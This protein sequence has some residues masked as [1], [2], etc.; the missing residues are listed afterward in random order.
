MTFWT[1][2]SAMAIIALFFVIGNMVSVKT[3]GYINSVL[4]AVIVF[5]ALMY[6]GVVPADI[7]TT[8]GLAGMVGTFVIP[9]CIVDVASKLKLKELKSEWKT[10]LIIVIASL[11]IVAICATVG[12]LA[13]GKARAIGAIGPL[14]GALL[15]TTI[16][17]QM[18]AAMGA[19]DVAVFVMIVLVLQML[20][21]LPVA[22]VCLKQYIKSIRKNGDLSAHV[23][24][25]AEKNAAMAAAAAGADSGKKSGFA[26]YVDCDYWIFFKIAIVGFIAYLVGTWLAPYT[27]S[28]INATLCYLIF[29]MIA[30]E[31]G[32]LDRGPLAKAHSQ[33]IIYFALFSLLLSTFA[34]VTLEVMLSQI[35]PAIAII[36]MAAAGML[37]FSGVL[38]KVLKVNPWLAMGISMCCYVGYPGSQIVAE[39]VIHGTP[40]LTA[41]EAAACSEMVIP[42]MI[43]GYFVAA[44]TSILAASVS[45]G[46]MF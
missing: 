37:V 32:F 34:S 23:L 46:F 38:G 9:F 13:I 31:I 26:K 16:S 43:L 36:L 24:R 5:L 21:G 42:K 41:E 28:I 25:L 39:E 11:G 17:Q 30:A 12:T 33:G 3:K 14:G 44:I 19:N 6:T 10:A 40:D 35:L 1:T 18:A 2:C 8:S 45:V 22:S 20:V 29:G 15:A 4:V 27:K 7:C